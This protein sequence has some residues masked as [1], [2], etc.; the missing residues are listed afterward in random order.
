MRQSDAEL[1]LEQQLVLAVVDCTQYHEQAWKQ[2]VLNQRSPHGDSETLAALVL[3]SDAEL[4]L[5][6]QL[7][8]GVHGQGSEQPELN[9]RPPH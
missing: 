4:E 1:E 7:V 6:Q 2:P 5:E 3:Q 9:Q 8:L